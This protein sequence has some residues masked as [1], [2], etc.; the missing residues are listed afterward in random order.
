MGLLM[1]ITGYNNEIMPHRC[2]VVGI[3]G[4]GSLGFLANSFEGVT[5]GCEKIIG[6]EV[7]FIAFL[8]GSFQNSL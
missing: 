8:C 7:L 1:A 5:W 6:G 4:G 2:T 3:P